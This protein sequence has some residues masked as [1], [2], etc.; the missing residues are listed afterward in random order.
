MSRIYKI[1]EEFSSTPGGRFQRN[2]PW[3]GEQF[4]EEVLSELVNEAIKTRDKIVIVL[5]GTSGYGSSFLEEA[6]GGLVRKGNFDKNQ[7]NEHL[8]IQAND[9]L[10]EIYRKSANRYIRDA[11]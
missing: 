6:F 8:E 11:H 9:P 1:A 7:L 10:Y 5:D 3:S 2:G 4:R